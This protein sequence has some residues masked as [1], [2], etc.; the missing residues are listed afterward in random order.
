MTILEMLQEK[1]IQVKK[2]GQTYKTLC[3]FHEETS[4]SM[5]VYPQTNT[6]FCFGCNRYITPKMV[7]D[8][9]G[10]SYTKL[11]RTESVDVSM[12]LNLQ[13]FITSM[14]MKARKLGIDQEKLLKVLKVIDE[15]CPTKI[16]PKDYKFYRN[17]VYSIFKTVLGVE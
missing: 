2:H 9:L 13:E 10:L 8:V 12:D 15:N 11:L 4:P 3:L 6:A 5:V 1:N 7:A 14:C 17:K 16:A